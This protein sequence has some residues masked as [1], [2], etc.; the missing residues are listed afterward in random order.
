MHKRWLVLFACITGLL[1]GL[2]TAGAIETGTPAWVIK[3]AV[4]R[5][6]PGH[7]YDAVGQVHGQ[8]KVRVDRCSRNWCQIRGEGDKGWVGLDNLSFGQY[9][10]GPL[11]GPKV[12]RPSGGPGVICL[13][14][15]S[16]YSGGRICS[17]SGTVVRDL[18]LLDRDN[19]YASISVEG[20]VSV[21][22]CRDRRF[23]NYCQVFTK[24][25]PS[26]PRFLNRAVS[27][28]RVY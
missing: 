6:G 13:Y 20:N 16:N 10:R 18:L 19:A 27:S 15:G 22:L 23:I 7:A 11:S 14:E 12:K 17:K 1:F 3:D 9:A 26:L 5:E 28:Y 24:S 21:M 8:I 4:L 2:P 25:Q